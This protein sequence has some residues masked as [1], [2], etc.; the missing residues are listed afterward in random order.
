MS[1][2][3]RKHRIG[4]RGKDRLPLWCVEKGSDGGGLVDIKR[5]DSHSSF[6]LV[7]EMRL[8]GNASGTATSSRHAG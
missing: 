1:R 7:Q 4:V 8:A 2:G 6:K 5:E 3:G